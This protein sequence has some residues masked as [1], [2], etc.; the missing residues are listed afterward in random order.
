[1]Y[2]IHIRFRVKAS[3]RRRLLVLH[4]LAVSAACMRWLLVLHVSA[5]NADSYEVSYELAA[6]S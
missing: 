4:A 2:N 5:V 3:Y 1:M 6:M